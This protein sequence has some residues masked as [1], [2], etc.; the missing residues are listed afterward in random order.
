MSWKKNVRR[1]SVALKAPHARKTSMQMLVKTLFRH[2]ELGI[3]AGRP[4]F[5]CRPTQKVNAGIRATAIDRH[6]MLVGDLM[7]ETLPVRTLERISLGAEPQGSKS[8]Y[9]KTYDSRPRAVLSIRAPGQSISVRS[10]LKDSL[11]GSTGFG[12]PKIAKARKPVL[13]AAAI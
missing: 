6:A 5:S 7:P 2:S 4:S 13:M 10:R 11:V 1:V 8:T 9:A 12:R 3:M